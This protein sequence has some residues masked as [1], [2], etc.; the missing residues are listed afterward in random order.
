MS[1]T[2]ASLL[3]LVLF[4]WVATSAT[5]GGKFL[6]HSRS[7]ASI[8]TELQGILGEV[9]G[10]GHG[11]EQRRLEKIRA[12][13]IPMFRALP[14]NQKGKAASQVMRYTVRRYFSQHHAWI[15]RGFEPHADIMNVS[16]QDGDILQNKIPDY[17]R[18]LLEEQFQQEGFSFDD[19][20]AM[21]A[22]IERLA[23]DEVVKSVE[24][25]F[26]LNSHTLTDRLSRED[27]MKVVSSYLMTEMLEGTDDKDQHKADLE[28]IRERYP[29]WDIT[30]LF[31]VDV[32]SSDI[33]G[34]RNSVSPFVDKETFTFEDVVRMSEAVSE[35][36]GPWSNHECHEMRDMLTKYDVHQTGRVRIADF[37]RS[38]VEGAWQ[39]LEPTQ[40]LRQNGALD[41]SSRYLGPQVIIANYIA[42]MSN[43]ITS[44]PYYSICCLNDCDQVF[45]HIEALIPAPTAPVAKILEAVET[46]PSAPIIIEERK[47]QLIEIADLHSG[48]VPIH[49]RLFS[50]WLHF[51][52]PHECPYPHMSGLSPK[53]QEQWRAQVG[54]DAESVSEDEVRQHLNADY[55]RRGASPD[56]GKGMWIFKETLLDSSTPSDA[57]PALT[58]TLRLISM[59]AIL[60]SF[61][62]LAFKEVHRMLPSAKGKSFEYN[63]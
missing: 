11:V 59:L 28:N 31:L 62:Y 42:G 44:A 50:Q 4:P 29:N 13:L 35:Q 53:T 43:C 47:N 46:M 14:K 9:L 20:V 1:N 61:G 26:H 3:A 40:F 33:F 49:G 25:A 7:S 57:M 27:L 54:E 8:R 6:G 56:A 24:L 34:R 30:Y 36:F 37:Y 2:S 15:V 16:E 12:A 60:G 10:H 22:A 23:F 58:R 39:F 17:I 38:T 5:H 51:V 32:V 19:M 52:F 48:L 55:G 18:S 45:Q 41:E 63:V 21:V